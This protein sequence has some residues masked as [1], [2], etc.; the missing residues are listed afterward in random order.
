MFIITHK[1]TRC[2]V[3]FYILFH[4]PL[5]DDKEFQK[6]PQSKI[7]ESDPHQ[8]AHY[9]QTLNHIKKELL[10]RC[11]PIS[12]THLHTCGWCHSDGGQR[13]IYTR[14][15]P[16]CWCSCLLHRVLALPGTHP[17]LR[18]DREPKQLSLQISASKE[19]HTQEKA[20]EG[21]KFIYLF[22]QKEKIQMIKES[23]LFFI[24][25][26]LLWKES[27]WKTKVSLGASCDSPVPER[28]GSS[29]CLSRKWLFKC[30]F[31]SPPAF[32]VTHFYQYLED[33]GGRIPVRN[34]PR[35]QS[36]SR[37]KAL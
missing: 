11:H 7:Q 34:S 9:T 5:P 1:H 22:G 12:Q 32:K 6:W 19:T 26:F 36:L 8:S 20:Q 35:R 31:F 30:T 29:S 24:S 2:L 16:Q 28:L 27:G 10:C 15:I 37:V 21:L 4:L 25:T 23:S 33:V 13:D 17:H 14:R 3:Y 18:G